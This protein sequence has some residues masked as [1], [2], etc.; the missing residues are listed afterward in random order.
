MEGVMMPGVAPIPGGMPPPAAPMPG[1]REQ[2]TVSRW[3]DRGFGFITPKDGGE[4]LFC[5]FSNVEDGN[6]L[7]PGSM[8]AFVKVYDD[9]KGKER[10]EQVT[11]GITM[12][13]NVGG[14]GMMGHRGPCFDWQKGQC[15][16]GAACRFSHEGD[17]VGGGFGGGFG[18][19][20]GGGGFG[21]RSRGVCFD[22]QKG[23]CTRGDACR[24]SH[25]EVGGAAFG[26]AGFGGAG[27]GGQPGFG[28]GG[29]G[30]QAGYA[31]QGQAFPQAYAGG[32]QQGGYGGYGGAPPPGPGFGAPPQVAGA[33][34]GFPNGANGAPPPGW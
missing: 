6:A 22:W 33:Y 7:E 16:R 10:A 1:G 23:Q 19:F 5:H 26:G 12:E 9:R 34:A 17:G 14:G 8:V 31:Q 21:G 27:F 32:G 25:G 18:G 15:T 13:R 30:G 24:F 4:D 28:A 2:G 29:F 11:G 20:G 3:T